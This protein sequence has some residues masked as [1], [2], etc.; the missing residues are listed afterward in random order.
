M[1]NAQSPIPN[2]YILHKQTADSR[3]RQYKQ[4]PHQQKTKVRSWDF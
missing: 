4:L 2:F 3:L 1:P